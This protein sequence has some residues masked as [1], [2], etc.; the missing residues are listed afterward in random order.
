[1]KKKTKKQPKLNKRQ[2]AK[3]FVD[4]PEDPDFAP[5]EVEEGEVKEGEE[6]QQDEADA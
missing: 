6:K 1:M 4:T 5:I 2:R 3:K